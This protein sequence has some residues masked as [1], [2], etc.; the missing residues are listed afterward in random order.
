MEM[1]EGLQIEGT[2]V[3]TRSPWWK[4]WKI[5]KQGR[6]GVNTR[7]PRWKCWKVCRRG[8]EESVGPAA[9]TS[10]EATEADLVLSGKQDDEDSEKVMD[11]IV[12]KKAE[13]ALRGTTRYKC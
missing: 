8:A 7:S 3:N 4:C 5:R 9:S 6:T 1:L 11:I 12:D 13:C 2:G 10:Q